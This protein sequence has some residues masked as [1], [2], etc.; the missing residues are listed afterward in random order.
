MKK[1]NTLLLTAFI[2]L[3]AVVPFSS[4]AHGHNDGVRLATDIVNLVGTSLY[5]G[6]PKVIYTT[7]T[8]FTPAPVIIEQAPVVVLP[9]PPPPPRIYY[10]PA[11][12]RYYI[13]PPPPPRYVPLPPP[14]YVV[15]PR[16]VPPRRGPHHVRP[17][18]YRGRQPG[19]IR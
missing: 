6:T 15:P 17:M 14:R 18:P 10:T 9:P 4:K 2:S 3:A 7:P 11:W 12:P 19:H 16:Y 5:W 13:A 8:V 1:K